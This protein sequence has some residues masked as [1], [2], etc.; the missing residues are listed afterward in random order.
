MRRW[1]ESPGLGAVPRD[2]RSGVRGAELGPPSLC[3]Q[4]L[5]LAYPVLPP[6]QRVG[7]GSHTRRRPPGA[8]HEAQATRPAGPGSCFVTLGKANRPPDSIENKY[9]GRPLGTRRCRATNGE[10]YLFGVANSHGVPSR[11]VGPCGS[12]MSGLLNQKWREKWHIASGTS[13]CEKCWS[14]YFSHRSTFAA[15]NWNFSNRKLKEAVVD[16]IRT[17][18]CQSVSFK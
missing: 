13:K 6:T 12:K 18:A 4:G 17:D 7:H 10:R 9:T 2:A 14:L 1:D 16:F 15:N 8:G 5:R 3:P 11:R